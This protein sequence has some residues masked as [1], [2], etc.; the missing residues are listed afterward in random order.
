M[1]VYKYIY[2]YILYIYYNILYIWIIDFL[3]EI[4]IHMCTN[5]S[6][7][8]ASCNAQIILLTSILS[9]TIYVD[10]HGIEPTPS[11]MQFTRLYLYTRSCVEL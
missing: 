10:Y 2:I 6:C 8:F 7:K 5:A 1:C 3:W 9:I 11:A 4:S